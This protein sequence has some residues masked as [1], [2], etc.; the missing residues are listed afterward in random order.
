MTDA[1]VID[2][3]RSRLATPFGRHLYAVIGT[4]PALDR[5]AQSLCTASTLDGRPFPSPISVNREILETIPD[6]EFRALVKTEARRPLP[7][8]RHVTQ[9][10]TRFLRS[11]LH[12]G[13]LIVLARMELLFTYKVELSPLRE[14]ATDLDRILL[15]LPGRRVGGRVMLFV[16]DESTGVSLP[17]NLIAENHLWQLET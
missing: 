1:E 6:D 12:G 7:T 10:F 9:A 3:L 8:T 5:F 13:G 2:E 17:T 16:E 15:L 11:R 4:Y 14:H